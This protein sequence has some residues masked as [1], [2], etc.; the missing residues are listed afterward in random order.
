MMHHT[1][2]ACRLLLAIF[3][4]TLSACLPSCELIPPEPAPPSDTPAPVQPNG[5]GL[6]NPNAQVGAM[7]HRIDMP[8]DISLDASWAEV[9]ELAVPV[10]M[11]GMWQA[12]GLRIGVL[13]AEQAQAFA[14]ALPVIHGESTATLISSHYPT[15][16]RSAPRLIDA[17]TIDLTAPPR[18][19]TLYRAR[20]G[21]LQLLA[22]IG[23]SDTG[24]AF[25]ELIPHHYKAKA[26]LIPRSPLEKQLDGRVFQTLS[27]MLPVSPDTAIIVGLH[28][29][30]P[31]EEEAIESTGDTDESVDAETTP[32]QAP[33]NEAE[34]PEADD[35]T[36][37]PAPV[38]P[39]KP[40]P[41]A[42]P[43]HM[44]RSL[45]AGTRAGH[46][47]QILLVI[48]LIEDN[49]AQETGSAAE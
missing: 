16:I 9:D 23:R 8:L 37:P 24:Q 17:V 19:P 25:L 6:P 45:M 44:G 27:A 15:A 29:P 33:S 3:A 34:A 42:I 5:P 31:V 30:W 49:P 43:N 36:Q 1:H 13:H 28:R 32:V 18:S 48:T 26:D 46:S 10:L 35:Q 47:T 21:R 38:A 4:V 20:G 41:P 40:Q 12:N 14:N 22:R 11:H 7:I 39:D 2:T